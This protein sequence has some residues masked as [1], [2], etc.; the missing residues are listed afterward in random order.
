M[1]SLGLWLAVTLMP[2]WQWYS[3]TAKLS[4][5]VGRRDSKIR[6]WMPLAAQTS[7]AARA[8]SMEWFRQSMQMATPR[9]LPSSPSAQMTWAK[10][11]VA[12]RMTWMFMLCR[13]TAMVPRRP[14]VPN[15][16]GP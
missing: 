1:Y 12:Q 11:W 8:N 5:G 3:R 13:P 10:P 7:A 2:A 14:A 16:R 6:T 15:S 9:R 4:S